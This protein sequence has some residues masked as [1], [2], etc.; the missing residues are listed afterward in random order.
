MSSYPLQEMA[1]ALDGVDD[2]LDPR[3]IRV[4]SRDRYAISPL[5]RDMLAD[6]QADAVVTPKTL[7][8]LKHVVSTAVRLR[9]PITVRGGGSANYGQSVPLKG[10][11]VLD[12]T[13]YSGIVA[14]GNGTIPVSYTHLRAHET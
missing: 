13:A 7:D 3:R 10:G 4:K 9:I 11:I 1:S 5:L 14:L 2:T 8:E 6:K 12:M